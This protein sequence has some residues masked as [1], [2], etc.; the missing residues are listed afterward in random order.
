MAQNATTMSPSTSASGSP[1][2]IFPLLMSGSIAH[3]S[4]SRNEILDLLCTMEE[5]AGG[6][7]TR[8]MAGVRRLLEVIDAVG[9]NSHAVDWMNV[10]QEKGIRLLDWE[11]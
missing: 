10:I 9:P 8:S 4:A 3:D 2:L 7:G 1:F 11:V 6:V 5:A